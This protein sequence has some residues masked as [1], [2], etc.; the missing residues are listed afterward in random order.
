MN[1][2]DRLK[3]EL[4]SAQS[5]LS[6]VT[7]DFH[8]RGDII[9]KY[10]EGIQ[11]TE[12]FGIVSTVATE[13]P[14][15]EIT[16][17]SD[18]ARQ[19]FLGKLSS[20]VTA[21]QHSDDIA[22]DRFA[23]MM[24]EKLAQK[25]EQGRGGW[26]DPDQCTVEL[27]NQLLIEHIP[28]G[29]PVDVANF[30]MMLCLRGAKIAQ[31]AAQPAT[32][33][34][35]NAPKLYTR[36]EVQAW[37]DDIAHAAAKLCERAGSPQYL[38][39]DVR[40]LAA[41]AQPAPVG[42]QPVQEPNDLARAF[43]EWTPPKCFDCKVTPDGKH[44]SHCP[45]WDAQ[46]HIG[47]VTKMIDANDLEKLAKQHPDL[48]FLKGTGILKLLNGIRQLEAEK[49]DLQALAIELADALELTAD[50]LRHALTDNK[51][52]PHEAARALYATSIVLAKVGES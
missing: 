25:R 44:Q 26:D 9:R 37:R 23:G 31:P 41:S 51:V 1:D 27:L 50:E 22:V 21:A 8:E 15:L 28:K 13:Y 52:R 3:D 38:I 24:K 30:C 42:A 19:E 20:V 32:A 6:I 34:G 4:R 47:D 12:V 43:N 33:V 14:K 17:V 11:L 16:F 5:A 40:A 29:D 35:V 39:A 48:C 36:E 45:E 46:D 10:R 18:G 7:R 2:V 49:R